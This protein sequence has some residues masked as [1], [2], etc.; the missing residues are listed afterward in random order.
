MDSLFVASMCCIA[1]S[2]R[3]LVETKMKWRDTDEFTQ[4]KGKMSDRW[5]QKNTTHVILNVATSL[6]ASLKNKEMWSGIFEL[7][8]K[9]FLFNKKYPWNFGPC[10]LPGI[11]LLNLF[12]IPEL[13]CVTISYT[14]CESSLDWPFVIGH[15]ARYQVHLWWEMTISL[16]MIM[17]QNLVVEKSLCR[18][19][20]FDRHFL[21]LSQ[22]CH[23]KQF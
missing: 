2:Q 21:P 13:L 7:M 20:Y 18:A 14:Y 4:G 5:S 23:E 16:H 6:W 11:N 22:N 12:K 1:K 19:L 8:K 15:A 17:K 9:D 10:L 3:K